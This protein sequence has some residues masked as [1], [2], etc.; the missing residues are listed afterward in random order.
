MVRFALL[1]VALLVATATS[2]ARGQDSDEVKLLKKEIALLQ[3]KLEAATLKIEKLEKENQQFKR[4][5]KGSTPVGQKRSLSDRLADGVVVKGDFA[6]TN[7]GKDDYLGKSTLTISERKDNA[8]KGTFLATAEGKPNF[9]Y[10]VSGTIT[11]SRVDIKS[12]G[13]PKPFT[14]N[15]QLSDDYL[16]LTFNGPVTKAKVKLKV[17]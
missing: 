3:A 5:G 11:G 12:V 4:D 2:Q 15:G 9:E 8:F 14:L 13:A 16:T 17:E 7:L 6:S 1:A 10:E